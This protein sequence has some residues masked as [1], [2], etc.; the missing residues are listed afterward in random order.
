M[1]ISIFTATFNRA[2][3]LPRLY[4]SICAQTDQD[5]EWIV[6]D[7]GS[8]DETEQLIEF[9]IREKKVEV[10]YFYQKNSGKHIAINEGLKLAKGDYFLSIDSDDF[11]AKDCIEICR[12]LSTEATGKRI[13]DG[14]TFI[15]TS[16]ETEINFKDFGSKRWQK[17]NSYKWPIKGEMSHVFATKIA[18]RFP[19]PVFEGENFCQESVQIIPIIKKYKILYSDY[20]LAF[21]DYLE[22]GLSQN[23][24]TRMLK[25]PRYAILSFKTKLMV[26]KNC[27]ERNMLAKNYWDIVLKTKQPKIKAFFGFP[28]ILSLPIL[29]TKIS[30]I[31]KNRR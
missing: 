25:N 12:K 18:R 6:V 17:Y 7:D 28:V 26:A 4:E 20:V 2:Y 27:A 23:L 24:Y 11:L 30:S 29:A 8:T 13:A 9:F 22:D 31:F 1:L 3:L 19:F 21:G 5:F 15:H 16:V 10:H 14:F